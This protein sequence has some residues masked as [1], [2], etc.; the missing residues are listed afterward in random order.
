MG[1]NGEWL[2]N[3]CAQGGQA[4]SGRAEIA[5]RVPLLAWLEFSATIGLT[6]FGRRGSGVG[7]QIAM[8]WMVEVRHPVSNA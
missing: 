2:D 1:V 4:V 8:H 7:T 6:D 3:R 5:L